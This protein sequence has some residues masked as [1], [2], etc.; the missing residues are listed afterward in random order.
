MLPWLGRALS[1]NFSAWNLRLSFGA[2]PLVGHLSYGALIFLLTACGLVSFAR[3]GWRP[4]VVTR[5]VGWS[6][7]LFALVFVLSTRLS[8]GATLFALQS[9]ASQA[10]II[11]SQFLTNNSAPPPSQFLGLRFDSKTMV[12][13]YALRLGWYLLIVAGIFLAGR[14]RRPNTR[15]QR[16]A[17]WA[18]AAAVA[19]TVAGLAFGLVSQSDLDGAVQAGAA[20]H[21]VT[22]ENL[23][24]SAVRW[25]PQ[26][27]YDTGFERALGAAQADQ[28]RTTG[29]AEYAQAV[30]PIGKDVTLL[31]Q[32]Q[33]FG[34]ALRS[35]PPGSAAFGVVE[36][37][38]VS[39][40]ANATVNAK[41]PALLDLAGGHLGSP[42]VSFTIGRFDYEAGDNALAIANLEQTVKD[43]TNSEVRSLA[44]TYIALAWE[45]RGNVGQFRHNVVAAVKAD[46]M[47]E[48]VYAR[49]LSA[50]LYVPG[51]P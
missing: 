32:A 42:A 15:P 44:L 6:Y 17:W 38:V 1:P 23:A 48:N 46:T 51:K 11:N 47:N 45:R 31:E 25:N 14:I 16:I 43:T 10:S 41:N 40:L 9:D 22:A 13:L 27:A 4:T 30:R 36:A 18:S 3:A 12:L 50:G 20:G 19:V 37:D 49:E 5:A 21:P 7:L 28:G 35:L 29:L 33:L 24:A 8:G 34:R 39:F 26:V 2:V